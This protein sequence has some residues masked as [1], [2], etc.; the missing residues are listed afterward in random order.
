MPRYIIVTGGV[1]SGLGKGVTTASIGR[2]ILG[3]G[4]SVTALKIDPYL[5]CDAG[6]MNPVEHGEVF[7]LDDGGEIDLD[8]GNYE[9]FLDVDLTKDHNLTTG[10]V[11]RE[12]ISKE[13]KGK[14]LGHTVQIIPHITD[15]IKNHIKSAGEKEILLV[16]MGGT[17]GDIESMP[18][19]EAARELRNEVGKSNCL[20][21]HVTYVPILKAVGEQKTKPTQ[22]SVKEL[23][24][25]GIAPDIIVARGAE[26]LRMETKR[27]ISLFCDVPANHVISA[28]DIENIYELPL[29]FE[30]QNLLKVILNHFELTEKKEDLK[31][32][33]ELCERIDKRKVERTLGIVGKYTAL[34]DSYR[35]ILEALVH[36]GTAYGCKVGVKWIEAEDL[37]KNGEEN[38]LKGLD[39]ILVP[40]GFGS[41]GV[42]GKIKAIK[43]A[44]E[45]DVPFLGICFGFQLATIEIARDLAGLRNAN[46]TEIEQDTE[47]PV[48][49]L[50]PEQREIK[51]LGGTMRLG[52]CDVELVKGTLAHRLY[53]TDRIRERH[54]HRYEFNPVY[55]E[56]IESTG[57]VFSG[58]CKE[59][60][61]IIELPEKKYFMASQFHPEFKSRPNRP[62]P[63]F[64]G[65]VKAMMDKGSIEK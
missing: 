23:R 24:S 63:L 55:K 21:V 62:V 9:R 12:V 7:V 10:A 34:A 5:N 57:A 58:Y 46:S 28:P 47:H 11:Y 64:L 8:L 33:R 51:E 37:E 4:Y 1:V 18:F 25:L 39:G 48:I 31:E 38:E 17:V 56:R 44:R 36:A 52:S 54:R 42:E 14:Y 13:R 3:A 49:T 50:L 65:L 35:S 15:H 59:R 61:E 26:E 32:W 45:N 60:A 30:K 53:G 19:L 27:K 41:R 20:F 2:L 29:L 40:G 22:H 16:E 6:T 43:Y